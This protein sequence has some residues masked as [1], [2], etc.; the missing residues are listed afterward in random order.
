MSVLPKVKGPR[1]GDYA[2]TYYALGREPTP[3]GLLGYLINVGTFDSEKEAIRAGE[4]A[5]L[6]L[7]HIG[8]VVT[9]HETGIAEA[10]LTDEA[11]ASRPKQ[12]ISDDV[13]SMYSQQQKQ[14]REKEAQ[15]RKEIDERQRQVEEEAKSIDDPTTLDYYAKKHMNRRMLEEALVAH[16]QNLQQTRK[17]LAE[18][19]QELATTDEKY[20]S[21]SDEWRAYLRSKIPANTGEPFFL[22]ER[23][24]SE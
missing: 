9:V 1:Q 16:E 15:Q 23:T 17:K 21:Y 3:S 6:K 5:R 19:R 10:M 14:Q 18:I 2:V 12:L 20:P 22:K 7:K 8:G 4:D 24:P 11:R 13:T